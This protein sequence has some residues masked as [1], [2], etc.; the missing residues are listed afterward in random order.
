MK[1]SAKRIAL[2][3]LMVTVLAVA[4]Q[5]GWIEQLRFE[6]LKANRDS[7]LVL[8]KARYLLAVVGYVLVFTLAIALALPAGAIMCLTGGFLFG[9]MPGILYVNMGAT[10][11]A[12]LSFLATRYII[13]DWV[14]ERYA[15]KLKVLNKTAAAEGWRYLLAIRLVPVLPFALVNMAAGL[16]KAKL[17]TFAW[18]TSL[19]SVVTMGIITY[20]GTELG[21]INDPGDV[22]SPGMI[23]A[24]SLLALLAFLPVIISVIKR[25][26]K[27]G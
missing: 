1:K 4:W 10:A 19:G 21:S 18:T 20:A 26:L 12:V 24:L 23:T 6:K 11:G 27:N 8:V 7:L 5:L 17:T 2:F 13:G 14:Q 16:T 9:F 15:D 22:L 25:R 3:L